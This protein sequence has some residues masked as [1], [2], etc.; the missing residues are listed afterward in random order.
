ML[1]YTLKC[2]LI[3]LQALILTVA[4][5][6]GV[7]AVPVFPLALELIAE[8]TY[9]VNQATPIAIVFLFS[10]LFGSM[11][12][13]AELGF[14]PGNSGVNG[15]FQE[16]I[17]T[18]SA[19]GDSTHELAKD[20]SGYVHFLLGCTLAVEVIYVFGFFPEM[21]RSRVDQADPSAKTENQAIQS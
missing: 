2:I 15:T 10:G 11:F 1:L 4:V 7:A 3:Q 17:Q 20:Y 9:P 8:T 12:L 14:E 19:A 21:K 16:H 6:S 5:I 18:C 13:G